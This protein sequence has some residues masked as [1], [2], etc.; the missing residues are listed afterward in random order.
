MNTVGI[1]STV[2]APILQ[3]HLFVNYHLNVGI[4]HI[5][6][7]FDDPDDE[8]IDFF[9]K[10]TQVTAVRCSSDYWHKIIGK[11]PES[12]ERRQ[13]INVNHGAELLSLKKI[14]WLIHIDCDELLRTSQPIKQI[15]GRHKTDAIR[16]SLF[17]AVAEKETYDHIFLPSL[18]KKKPSKKQ[19]SMAKKLG[20]S[21]AIFEGEFL[22]GHMMSKSAVR[23]SNKT[24][25]K[26]GIHGP[27]KSHG[28]KLTNTDLIQL[29]HFDCVSID[30][31]KMKW[32]RRLDGTGLALRMRD[33]RKKQMQL[34]ES[35][36]MEGGK[37][38]SSMFNKLH[39]IRRRERPILYILGMLKRIY[40]NKKMFENPTFEANQ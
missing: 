36:K 34:Y 33:N 38:L 7:F 32:D 17:E 1:I 5:I 24:K 11:R 15:I 10:Y 26:H 21:N 37:A 30:D 35:A 6:L 40:I 39:N 20:C 4:D 14:D 28:L 8:G 29:L 22:R 2:K 19:I 12:I 25:G 23:I 13:T 3:L 27:K 18:F 16:F 31:W 9:S